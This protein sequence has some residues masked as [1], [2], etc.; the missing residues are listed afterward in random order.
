MGTR[1]GIEL[2]VGG[3]KEMDERSDCLRELKPGIEVLLR[4]EVPVKPVKFLEA[5]EGTLDN[6]PVREVVDLEPVR[7]FNR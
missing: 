6:P 7:G 3:G 1:D 5:D 2:E 4:L